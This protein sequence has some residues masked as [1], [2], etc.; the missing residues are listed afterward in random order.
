MADHHGGPTRHQ[1]TDA[2]AQTA[3]EIDELHR[4]IGDGEPTPEQTAWWDGLLAR[5]RDDTDRLA[6]LD[7][8]LAER[9]A[10]LPTVP[11]D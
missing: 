6:A 5:F 2:I 7:A 1:L 3:R 9:L 10:Q 4:E 8:R 11:G